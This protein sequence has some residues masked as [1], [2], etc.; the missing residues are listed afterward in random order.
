MVLTDEIVQIRDAIIEAIPVETLY[1]FGSY[2]YGTPNAN[3]DYD[4]YAV[5]T[6]DTMQPFDAAVKAR[7]SLKK[8]NRNTAVDIL[9]DSRSR[10]NE[11]KQFNTL[12]QKV[13]R[14]GIV[15]YERT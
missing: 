11:R 2:A 14:E 1:L 9:A 8:I 12:E 13:A 5:I 6:D 10:F 15:L 3:S 7:Q 4:F